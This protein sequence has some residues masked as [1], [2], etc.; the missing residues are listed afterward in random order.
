MSL[1]MLL[2]RANAKSKGTSEKL[3]TAPTKFV[4]ADGIRFAYRSFGS[5]SGTPL[6]FLQHF[7]GTMDDWDP[8]VV[9]GLAKDRPVVVFDNTGVGKSSGK[10]PDNV[11]QMATDAARFMSALGVR[12]VDLLGFSLGG[13]VAQQLAVD[14][15]ELVRRIVLAGTAPQ[16]G[17][18]HLLK[19]LGEAFSQKDASDP[20]LYLFFTHSG[21]SQ[22]AGRAFLARVN[23][24]KADRDPPSGKEITDPQAK[25]IIT[26]CAMKDP[27]HSILKAI[28]QPVLVVNGSNDI[29]LPTENS[30]VMFKHLKDA[31]LILYPDSGH[32]A[33]FQYADDFV[34]QTTRFL[35]D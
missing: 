10:T 7:S 19:V 12:N 23:S 14:H 3:E 32:G 16:G 22:A 13:L 6:V 2:E 26:W 33:L 15:P 8:A 21:A 35:T 27:E 30:Y 34:Y 25:A 24:R 17:D 31:K 18:E 4:E 29:M 28:S 11:L 5:T 20:R 9:N 1:S